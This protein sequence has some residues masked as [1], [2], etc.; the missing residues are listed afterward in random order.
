MMSAVK[1]T[2]IICI[3]VCAA[4]IIAFCSAAIVFAVRRSKVNKTENG[5]FVCSTEAVGEISLNYGKFFDNGELTVGGE[6]VTAAATADG[7]SNRRS[8]EY[9]GKNYQL[10]VYLDGY[11]AEGWLFTADGSLPELSEKLNF[12]LAK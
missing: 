8:F 6:N 5:Y 10:A 7:S 1:K 9:G 4:C 12:E 11:G 3:A 2:V